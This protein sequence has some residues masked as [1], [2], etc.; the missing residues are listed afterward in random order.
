MD[1]LTA[2]PTHTSCKDLLKKCCPF[3]DGLDQPVV[4]SLQMPELL[5]PFKKMNNSLLRGR[6][7]KERQTILSCMKEIDR[8][9]TDDQSYI[10]DGDKRKRKAEVE[11]EI[12]VILVSMLIQIYKLSKRENHGLTERKSEIDKYVESI[13]HYINQNFRNKVTLDDLAQ[14]LNLSKFYLSRIFKEVT[15]MTVMDYVMACRLNQVKYDLEINVE[16][17]VSEI[18]A[19]SGFESS[20]V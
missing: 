11:T 5:A 2:V 20:P 3:F 10:L 13:A 4:L 12:K 19:N 7:E 8:L 14:S 9:T 15:G 1:G 16:K 6:D 17:S 18:A